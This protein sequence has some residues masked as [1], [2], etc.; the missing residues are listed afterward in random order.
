MKPLMSIV[1]MR[2]VPE[3]NT[4]CWL[5]FGTVNACGYAR[6][7]RGRPWKMVHREVLA[8]TLGNLIP[9]GLCVCHRCDQPCCVNPAHLFLGT[10]AD[11]VR[12]MIRKGR[13]GI[14]KQAPLCRLGHPRKLSPTSG[15]M[16]C[17]TCVTERGRRRKA[18]IAME[19]P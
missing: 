5:W 8:L 15:R 3:P 6:V 17:Q 19:A 16:Y 4:G 2:S 10:V 18:R 14:R 12:D 13:R 11:N 1:E 9:A 7:R